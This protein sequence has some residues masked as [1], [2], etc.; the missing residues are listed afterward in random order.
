MKLSHHTGENCHKTAQRRFP[1]SGI[2]PCCSSATVL[3]QG[4]GGERVAM[5]LDPQGLM[6]INLRGFANTNSL[7]SQPSQKFRLFALDPC[8]LWGTA[9]GHLIAC[10]RS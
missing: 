3:L 10:V 4:K 6:D 2:L 8:R 7:A 5:G 1:A 9:S